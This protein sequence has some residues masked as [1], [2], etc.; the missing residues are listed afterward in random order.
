[1]LRW[2]TVG[3]LA[4]TLACSQ[5]CIAVGTYLTVK[6]VYGVAEKGNTIGMNYHAEPPAVWDAV[7]AQLTDMELTPKGK[8]ELKKDKGELKAGPLTVRVA[9]L[10]KA[11]GTRVD[12]VTDLNKYTNVRQARL[13]LNGAADRLGEYDEA[14]QDFPAGLDAT[15]DAAIAQ[16]E[17]MGFKP[18]RGTTREEGRAK[19]RVGDTLI[20]LEPLTEKRTRVHVPLSEANPDLDLERAAYLFEGMEDRL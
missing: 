5:G 15:Y 12:V 6:A 11:P 19:I 13:L 14:I 1:M 10:Q 3:V 18:G 7:Q 16:L 4:F 9:P 8:A 17:A 20:A 2:L